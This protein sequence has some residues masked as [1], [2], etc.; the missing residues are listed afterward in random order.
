M[1]D[2]CDVGNGGD[3]GDGGD[4][5]NVGEGIKGDHN[6]LTALPLEQDVLVLLRIR[7]FLLL[8]LVRLLSPTVSCVLKYLKEDFT[9]NLYKYF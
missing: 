9:N 2:V 8:L 6:N 3:V 7:H 4:D 1:G 5:G